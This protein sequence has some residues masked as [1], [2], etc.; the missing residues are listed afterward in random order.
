MN[1]IYSGVGR[2]LKFA[3]APTF[4]TMALATALLGDG[5][6]SMLCSAEHASLL[7]GMMPMYLLMSTFH[8]P[9]WLKLIAIRAR[10]SNKAADANLAL[11]E[12]GSD[13]VGP[14]HATANRHRL[15]RGRRP[16]R[17]EAPP[18]ALSHLAF[19]LLITY[20]TA[21]LGFNR[22]NGLGSR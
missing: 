5:G 10:R 8:S 19:L 15:G 9:P 17:R 20:L 21:G 22:F 1:E 14:A 2:T 7:S 12:L 13:D 3:A 16:R 4:A 11:Q 6:T 18:P